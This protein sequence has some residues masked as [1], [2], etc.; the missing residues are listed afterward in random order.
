MRRRAVQGFP[1][2]GSRVPNDVS[3]LG[4]C[5]WIRAILSFSGTLLSTMERLP[6]LSIVVERLLVMAVCDLGFSKP[7][8][9]HTVAG[10]WKRIVW[11]CKNSHSIETE[12]GL[13]L[14]VSRVPNDVSSSEM[15]VER[16]GICGVGDFVRPTVNVSP[17]MLTSTLGWCKQ[18]VS[19]QSRTHPWCVEM[20]WT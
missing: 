15:I 11:N 7:E 10:V 19:V 18:F 14:T 20:V 5:H 17:G 4:M 1:L 6:P 12:I 13:V 16:C 3:S 8:E 2:T 9:Y